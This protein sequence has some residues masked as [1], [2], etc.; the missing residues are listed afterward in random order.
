[1]KKLLLAISLLLIL[2]GAGYRTVS[3]LIDQPATASAAETSGEKKAAD[4][5]R[6]SGIEVADMP[7]DVPS[8]LKS[9]TGFTLSFNPENCTP[10]WVGWELLASEARGETGRSNKFWTDESL[11]NCPY[12]EDYRHSGYDRGHMCPAA[13]QKW[14]ERAMIDCFVMSNICPQDHSLNSGAWQ[15]LEKKERKWAER[16]GAIVIVAGPVYEKT[17]TKRIGESGVRV[18]SAFFKVICAPYIKEP[19]AIGFV[20]PN[21]SSPGNM[22][23]YVMTVDDVEKLT[24]FDF[25]SALPDEIENEIEKNTSFREW[26]RN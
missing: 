5:Q 8:L 3:E 2:G 1:M 15:T 25:F 19:R 10:N 9:Y 20:Y 23:Q 4:G 26:N 12:T 24:G 11:R 13:D 22:E 14:S 6:I 7:H 18:P 21:M 17:D 16:D